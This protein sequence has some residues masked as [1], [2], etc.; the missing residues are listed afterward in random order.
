MP[1]N[2]KAQN[3]SKDRR[4][5]QEYEPI[6]EI[7][8]DYARHMY[9]TENQDVL[10]NERE[11]VRLGDS[12]TDPDRQ[13]LREEGLLEHDRLMEDLSTSSPQRNPSGLASLEYLGRPA[14]LDIA[15][16]E[17]AHVDEVPTWRPTWLRPFVLA[18]F[19]GLFSCAAVA[20]LIMLCYSHKH[21]GLFRTGSTL[22]F[23][24]KFGPTAGK[25]L[26]PS[27]PT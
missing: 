15:V 17:K 22:T 7:D 18:T 6:T 19:A 13:H 3:L 8:E 27:I 11:T 9:S 20:L 21:D 25:Q 16:E 12:P 10:T 1:S 26:V 24:W 4:S 5:F 23:W 2:S 14:A